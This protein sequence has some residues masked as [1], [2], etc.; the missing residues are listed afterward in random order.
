M[1][2]TF[3]EKKKMVRDIL[4]LEEHQQIQIFHILDDKKVKYSSNS[5]GLLLNL[6]QLDEKIIEEINDY[7]KRCMKDNKYRKI[8]I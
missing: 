1:T 7:V 4:T 8:E 5:N 2:L 6:S 3:D